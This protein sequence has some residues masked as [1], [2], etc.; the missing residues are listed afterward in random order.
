LGAP[1]ERSEKAKNL[2][3]DCRAEP[4]AGARVCSTAT[5]G[6]KHLFAADRQPK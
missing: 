2:G 5:R 3:R 6:E 1:P 4:K